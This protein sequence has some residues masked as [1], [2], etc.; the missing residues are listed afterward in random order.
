MADII[1]FEAR[2]KKLRATRMAERITVEEAQF[3]MTVDQ[4]IRAMIDSPINS[5]S[6]ILTAGLIAMIDI[7]EA[8]GKERADAIKTV[9]Q[10]ISLFR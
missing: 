4:I 7:L 9:A 2:L 1:D 8:S 3:E 10:K 6:E 5:L